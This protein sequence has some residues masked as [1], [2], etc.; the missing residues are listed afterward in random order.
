[1]NRRHVLLAVCGLASCAVVPAEPKPEYTVEE[2]E[3]ALQRA[4]ALI[5]DMDKRLDAKDAQIH[6]MHD[7]LSS[8][9]NCT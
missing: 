8:E 1:V 6:A 2:L 5:V 7:Q 3:T 4:V 9:L